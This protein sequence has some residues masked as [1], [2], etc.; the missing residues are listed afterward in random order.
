MGT[1]QH[2]MPSGKVKEEGHE[3]DLPTGPLFAPPHEGKIVV[4][5]EGNHPLTLLPKW[6]MFVPWEAMKMRNQNTAMCAKGEEQK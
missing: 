4:L 1:T 3:F 6:D 5:E 2:H